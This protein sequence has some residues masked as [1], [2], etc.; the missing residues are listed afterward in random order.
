MDN[1]VIGGVLSLGILIG[2]LVGWFVNEVGDFSLKA[3]TGAISALAG[4]GVIAIFSLIAPSSSTREFW[5]YPMGLLAGLLIAPIVSKL[6]DA[7]Y[8]EEDPTEPSRT[9]RKK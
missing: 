1:V 2:L 5:F 3:L 4:S 9:A 6:S 8:D 7:L